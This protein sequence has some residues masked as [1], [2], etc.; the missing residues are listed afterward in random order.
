MHY[1]LKAKYYYASETCIIACI[2]KAILANLFLVFL[3]YSRYI[4]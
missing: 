1:V 3:Y 2:K 4:T